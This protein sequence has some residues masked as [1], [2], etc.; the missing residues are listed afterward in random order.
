MIWSSDRKVDHALLDSDYPA[1]I[2]LGM[3]SG[4]RRWAR[5]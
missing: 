4:M 1:V 3:H 5:Q 2:V